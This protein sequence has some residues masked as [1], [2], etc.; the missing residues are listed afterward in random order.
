GSSREPSPPSTP[1]VGRAAT[2]AHQEGANHNKGAGATLQDAEHGVSVNVQA[3]EAI[4]EEVREVPKE[5]LQSVNQFIRKQR[6]GTIDVW[7]LYDDGG[8]TMLIPYL[9]TT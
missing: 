8:L 5:V 7:W 2:A 6:K 4:P 1:H 9:L 3:P